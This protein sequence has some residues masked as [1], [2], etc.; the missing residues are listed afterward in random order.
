MKT[1]SAKS[2][3]TSAAK[4]GS[5]KP[6]KPKKTV[7]KIVTH[8]FPADYFGFCF[9]A[10]AAKTFQVDWSNPA[11]GVH[12][13]QNLSHLKELID[14]L[15]STIEMLSAN[16]V[17]KYADLHIS[18]F[19]L[20]PYESFETGRSNHSIVIDR[21]VDKNKYAL[22][23]TADKINFSTLDIDSCDDVEVVLVLD[24]NYQRARVI[25]LSHL[26]KR[27]FKNLAEQFEYIAYAPSTHKQTLM[28]K[29]YY[30]DTMEVPMNRLSR[31]EK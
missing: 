25:K 2:D 28:E 9:V 26:A 13:H 10:D 29:V 23:C 24:H 30:A 22:F 5:K 20:E 31:L 4:A 6:A 14:L 15:E 27:P 1:S 18:D 11:V 3:K 7:R 12:P 21:S 17:F 8:L 16:S 19:E